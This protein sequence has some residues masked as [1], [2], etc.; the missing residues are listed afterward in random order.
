[1]VHDTFDIKYRPTTQAEFSL[2]QVQW[3]ENTLIRVQFW[4]RS[5]ACDLFLRF[6]K[7]YVQDVAG[8]ERYGN[9][10]RMY[11]QNALGAIVVFDVSSS[12]SFKEAAMWASDIQSKVSLGEKVQL[13]MIL[14]ANKGT[15]G[16]SSLPHRDD[17]LTQVDMKCSGSTQ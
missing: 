15:W 7:S 4:V 2:K 10:T 14:L 11:Y 1:M 6:I 12:T 9:S 16:I 5:P 8:Q 13:P 17:R 3:D